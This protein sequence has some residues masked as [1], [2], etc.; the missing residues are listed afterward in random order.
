MVSLTHTLTHTMKFPYGTSGTRSAKEEADSQRKGPKMPVQHHLKGFGTFV[1]SRSRVRV[2]SLA[3][4]R[5][6][7]LV[8]E[9][10]LSGVSDFAICAKP[11]LVGSFLLRF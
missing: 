8:W 6:G 11:S 3:P 5:K 2:T 7:S 9:P 1:I 10:F 4:E